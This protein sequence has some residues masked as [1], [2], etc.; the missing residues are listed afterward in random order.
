[1]RGCEQPETSSRVYEDM[2]PHIRRTLA[3]AAAVAVLAALVPAAAASRG[4]PAVTLRPAALPRGDGPAVPLVVGSTILD[5]S[6]RVA[7]DAVDVQLLGES[8]G[9]YVAVVLP[10]G[11]PGRVERISLDG[12]RTT[13]LDRFRG[14]TT[15]SQDGRALFETVVGERRPRSVVRVLDPW[16][17]EPTS[18]RVFRGYLRVLDADAGRAVLGVSHP[19]RTLWWDYE[20]DTV[21][22]ISGQEAYVADVR[23][24]RVGTYTRDVG[25][26]GCS[27]LRPLSAPRTVLWRS[28][29]HSVA[30]V[31]PDGRRVLARTLSLDGPI[32]TLAVRTTSGRV[33]ATYR[34]PA[35][36]GPSRW[37][38]PRSVVLTT[39]GK[40][41]LA[42]VRC[43]GGAVCERA[44][45]LHP[46]P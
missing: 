14:E 7:V 34:A 1:V 38:S 8:A 12:D 35:W 43:R 3:C 18:R 22:R 10:D 15:L 30:A 21:R 24:D 29:E 5:G 31:S 37:E 2:N 17:G 40:D 26:G 11:Q 9:D 6:T 32:T 39:Y 13:V 20:T 33:V 44:S 36:F 19:A 46:V 16:T 45:G 23:A 41:T 42:L 4:E 27:V 28:C 25:A